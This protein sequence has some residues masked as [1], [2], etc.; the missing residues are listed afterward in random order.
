MHVSGCLVWYAGGCWG[1]Y[2]K[3]GEWLWSLQQPESIC[4]AH[5]VIDAEIVYTRPIF[6]P[7][8]VC[9]CISVLT[10]VFLLL[11]CMYI[12]LPPYTHTHTLCFICASASIRWPWPRPLTFELWLWERRPLICSP[13]RPPLLLI[14]PSISPRVSRCWP[15][16]SPTFTI[17]S[18]IRVISKPGG[19]SP[20]LG[21][22]GGPNKDSEDGAG[23][24]LA[25]ALYTN[26]WQIF[27]DGSSRVRGLLTCNQVPWARTLLSMLIHQQTNMI[28]DI[29]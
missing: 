19:C 8:C 9:V 13:S 11:E 20:S 29:E 27:R 18:S 28:A 14:S 17:M 12:C 1:V 2:L 25:P 6:F 4:C 15:W 26:E 7:H 3:A 23:A 24:F 10:Y 21:A 5:T 16:N 22:A